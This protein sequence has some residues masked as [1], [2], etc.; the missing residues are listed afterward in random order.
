[1]GSRSDTDIMTTGRAVA[2][3]I[4]LMALSI[5][6]LS[7]V[8]DVMWPFGLIM[9]ILLIAIALMFLVSLRSRVTAYECAKCGHVFEI[10]AVKDVTSPHGPGKGGGWKLLTCPKCGERSRA[11]VILT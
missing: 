10:D 11:R 5:M 2:G 6:V 8:T 3:I 1:M 7:F 9:G 4:L